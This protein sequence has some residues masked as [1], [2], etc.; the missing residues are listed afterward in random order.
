MQCFPT[1]IKS[2][3]HVANIRDNGISRRSHPPFQ[4]ASALGRFLP[5]A[6][7]VLIQRIQ[8]SHGNRRQ[9][10]HDHVGT[11]TQ[12]HFPP[13]RVDRP[14]RRS[15]RNQ[16]IGKQQPQNADQPQ[17]LC[18]TAVGLF[19]KRRV[20]MGE[21]GRCRSCPAPVPAKSV[22]RYRDFPLSDT[23]SPP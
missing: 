6:N 18:K 19:P 11:G 17:C 7:F 5:C 21:I 16:G 13:L 2:P 3:P 4:T 22:G 15:C 12:S 10:R 14:Q 9:I 1:S 20:F 8:L 23:V